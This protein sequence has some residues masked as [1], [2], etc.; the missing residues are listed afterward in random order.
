MQRDQSQAVLGQILTVT[1]E[2]DEQLDTRPRKE[3]RQEEP[4]RHVKSEQAK[5]KVAQQKERASQ[6]KAKLSPMNEVGSIYVGQPVANGSKPLE[7]VPEPG[8]P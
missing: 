5:A 3:P 2:Q 4:R 7:L 1:E 8:L 6:R